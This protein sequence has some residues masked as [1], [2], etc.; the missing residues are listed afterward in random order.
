MGF[1]DVYQAAVEEIAMPDS[2]Q[3]GTFNPRARDAL[4]SQ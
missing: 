4:G 1:P 2:M 3:G